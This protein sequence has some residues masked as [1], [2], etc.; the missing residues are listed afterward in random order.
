VAQVLKFAEAHRDTPE[1]TVPRGRGRPRD[2]EAK[3]RILAAA[4]EAVEELGF[5]T[6]SIDAIAD[7]AGASKATI[8]RWWPNKAALLIEALRDEVAHEVP[9]PSTGDLHED[10]RL[11]L[12]NFIRLLTGRRGRLF[13]AFISAA[14]NDDEVAMA[15]RSVWIAPR[16]L[17]AKRVLEGHLHTGQLPEDADLDLI[18]DMLYGPLYFRLLAGHAGL[19]DKVADSIASVALRGISPRLSVTDG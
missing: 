2:E 4:L 18:L 9:F 8:Y 7:R 11:Q 3:E 14:Q 13:K 15:F 5:S 12:R 1:V 19:C 17:E 16:R 6:A 10:I